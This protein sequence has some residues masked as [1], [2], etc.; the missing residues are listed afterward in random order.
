MLWRKNNLAI[1]P[2]PS[3]RTLFETG[4]YVKPGPNS[5]DRRNDKLNVTLPFM[6]ERRASAGVCV[7][8][9]R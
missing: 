6:A 1:S 2:S 7:K 3:E 8:I 5:N 9:A 4:P